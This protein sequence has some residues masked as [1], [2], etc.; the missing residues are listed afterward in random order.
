VRQESVR[1]AD[2][3]LQLSESKKRVEEQEGKFQSLLK[4]KKEKEA[5]LDIQIQILQGQLAELRAQNIRLSTHNEY[6]D[7]KEKLLQVIAFKSV[8]I[9]NLYSNL[10]VLG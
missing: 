4:E 7:T 10:F 6:A 1:P 9:S 2:I 8:L 5:S 3:E